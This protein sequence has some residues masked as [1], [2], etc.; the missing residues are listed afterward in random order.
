MVQIQQINKE[1]I[2]D[3]WTGRNIGR[4]ALKVKKKKRLPWQQLLPL[5]YETAYY[6]TFQWYK[7]AVQIWWVSV[8]NCGCERTFFSD[9]RTD[10]RMDV[11]CF[12]IPLQRCWR[13]IKADSAS[14]MTDGMY[15][16]TDRGNIVE[17][18]N[19]KRGVM[20]NLY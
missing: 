4:Y 9:G 14:R 3:L 8:K 6:K 1:D 19:E 7:H 15:M 10:G 20:H 11:D 2:M 12:Y 17:I 16:E 13:G 18:T 5:F